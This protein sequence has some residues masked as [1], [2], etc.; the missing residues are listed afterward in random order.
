RKDPGRIYCVM[1]DGE[2]AEGAVW[3]AAEIAAVEKL[4]NLCAVVDVNGLGQSGRT[5]HGHDIDAIAAK[6]RAFGWHAVGVDGHDVA[7]LTAA[8]ADARA[9]AGKPTGGGG[10]THGGRGGRRVG[11]RGGGRDN[12]QRGGGGGG[13]APAGGGAPPLS[14]AVEAR[15]RG[16][17][18]P[19]PAGAPLDPPPPPY[20]VGDDVAAREAWGE[21]LVKLGAADP[22][23][24][25]LDAEVKNSTYSEKFK[26]KFPARFLDGFIAD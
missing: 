10:R 1:G 20:K 24:I 23:V 25:A 18:G 17:A 26:D 8:F 15:V 14:L 13:G 4:D 16:D 7:A 3:E 6:W 9:T 11:E 21:A 22:R 12:P 2:I 5:M 19:K